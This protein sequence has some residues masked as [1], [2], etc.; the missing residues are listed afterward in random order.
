MCLEHVWIGPHTYM[1]TVVTL[2][3]EQERAA[4]H[5]VFRTAIILNVGVCRCRTSCYFTPLKYLLLCNCTIREKEFSFQGLMCYPRQLNAKILVENKY[6]DLER[7]MNL[8]QHLW[9]QVLCCVVSRPCTV[10]GRGGKP[11]WT[12]QPTAWCICLCIR[13][14]EAGLTL[15]KA[16]NLL[17]VINTR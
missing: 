3:C 10:T 7:W 2:L 6:L 4:A 17:L 13:I 5:S 12:V 15:G 9:W 1:E 14:Y 11:W 16:T 8:M